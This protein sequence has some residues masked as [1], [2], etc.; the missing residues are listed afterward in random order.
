MKILDELNYQMSKTRH[1]KNK[2]LFLFTI[3]VLVTGK[4]MS[5]YMLIFLAALYLLMVVFLK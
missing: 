2:E 1:I 3:L 4:L 5:V